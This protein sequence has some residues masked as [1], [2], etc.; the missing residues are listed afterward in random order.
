[1]AQRMVLGSHLRELRE[2]LG[3]SVVDAG[4]HIGAS[5]SKISR[6]E[7]GQHV[8]KARDIS[9]LLDFYGVSDAA[10]RHNLMELLEHANQRPWWQDW[11]DVA[12]KQL[13]TFVS[14]E[15]MAQRIR[16]YEP[17]QLPGLLQTEEYARAVILSGRE[18]TSRREVERLVDLR[19][20]RRLRFEGA[21]PKRL[22]SVIDE[23]TL[24]RPFGDSGI[25][26]RQ[27]DHLIALT[28][29]HSRY[30]MRIAELRKPNLPV[31][32]GSTTIF[33]FEDMLLPSIVYTEQFDGAFILQEEEQVDRRVKGFDRLQKASLS[34][35]GSAQRLRDLRSAF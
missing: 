10:E 24:I 31:V 16:T 26:R 18:A 6:L 7:T 33:D 3:I 1:M 5:G 30:V 20:H 29:Q 2:G 35:K 4:R 25:M 22:I 13:Q 23:V 8:Y 28:E 27:L 19:Q 32:L 12:T 21:P 9:S 15:E 14:F 17:A 34:H 11:S